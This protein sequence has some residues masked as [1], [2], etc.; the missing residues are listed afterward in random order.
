[1]TAEAFLGYQQQ[2]AY[3]FRRVE[4]E[5]G[6]YVTRIFPRSLM[7]P[8]GIPDFL[9]RTRFLPSSRCLLEGRAW[10]GWAPVTRVEV[11]LDGG[12]H[13]A[14]ASLGKPVAEFAWLPWSFAW[15]A[16]PGEH[17]LCSRAIDAAGNCQP[18]TPNWNVEGVQNNAVQCLRVEVGDHIAAYQRTADEARAKQ[19]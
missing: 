6:D 3:R 4:E 16:Q 1:V 12:R 17:E 14:A 7:V 15:D 5:P 10:S 11:S 18:L 13:W 19:T 8:P 9:S 2:L